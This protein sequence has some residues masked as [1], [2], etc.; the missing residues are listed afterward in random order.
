MQIRRKKPIMCAP[1]TISPSSTVARQLV[2]IQGELP[3]R[4]SHLSWPS[5]EHGS[6]QGVRIEVQ[7]QGCSSWHAKPSCRKWYIH[8]LALATCI[9]HARCQLV[10]PETSLTIST[11]SQARL[12]L[13][14]PPCSRGPWSRRCRCSQSEAL[15]GHGA[16]Q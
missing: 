13:R 6:S 15:P 8:M 4:L 9:E 16:R 12:H 2:Q 3:P 10:V 5:C 14:R 1:L 11:P 7:T